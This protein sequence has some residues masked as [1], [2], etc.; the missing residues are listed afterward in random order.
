MAKIRTNIEIDELSLKIVM[1]RYH[2]QTK[3]DA[4]NL[5]LRHLA[6]EPM[7]TEEALEMHGAHAIG[8]LPKDYFP[9]NK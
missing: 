1:G 7:T 8:R 2:L 4:V 9:K 6:S 5:A 3:T